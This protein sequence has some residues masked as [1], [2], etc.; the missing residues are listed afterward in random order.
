MFASSKNGRHAHG[1]LWPGI[2]VRLGY[3]KK[4]GPEAEQQKR[5][6][7]GLEGPRYPAVGGV[8]R[9]VNGK[10]RAA[11]SQFFH[12]ELASRAP[13]D[14]LLLPMRDPA[15]QESEAEGIIPAAP[16]HAPA[17]GSHGPSSECLRPC[18]SRCTK[19]ETTACGGVVGYGAAAEIVDP[20]YSTAHQYPYTPGTPNRPR[21]AVESNVQIQ[22]CTKA[23]RIQSCS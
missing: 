20:P 15:A 13:P 3:Q 4:H 12:T 17:P 10:Q 14:L 22:S 9:Q 19:A 8:V 1:P 11:S 2:D 16:H 18:A 6:I 7:Y 5:S 23:P 21:H